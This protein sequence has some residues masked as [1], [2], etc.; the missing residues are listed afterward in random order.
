MINSTV[1]SEES[2][3]YQTNA[4]KTYQP[5]KSIFTNSDITEHGLQ[6]LE[7][8]HMS[9]PTIV[10]RTSFEM[11]D[12]PP[13]FDLPGFDVTILQFLE[14]HRYWLMYQRNPKKS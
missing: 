3:S 5:F 14:K 12:D 9:F 8:D 4:A 10:L 11:S 1:V 13:E 6:D 7:F 2:H